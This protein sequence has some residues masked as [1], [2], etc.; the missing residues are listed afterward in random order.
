M[1]KEPQ[2]K[3]ISAFIKSYIDFYQIKSQFKIERN[4][5]LDEYNQLDEEV[6]EMHSLVKQVDSELQIFEKVNTIVE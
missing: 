4:E 1:D 5:L 2:R 3:C 6:K